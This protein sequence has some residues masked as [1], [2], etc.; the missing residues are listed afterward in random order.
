MEQKPGCRV[1]VHNAT[2]AGMAQMDNDFLVEEA[3]PDMIRVR[4]KMRA[5]ALTFMIG[6]R[7]LL[8][9]VAGEKDDYDH[10]LDVDARAFAQEAA[11]QRNL[12]DKETPAAFDDPSRDDGIRPEGLNAENDD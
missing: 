1:G 6:D 10:A 11:E 8:G 2:Q 9:A 3:R 7:K 5:A 12:V 4:H